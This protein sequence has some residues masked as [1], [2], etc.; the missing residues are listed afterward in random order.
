MVQAGPAGFLNE[1]HLVGAIGTTRWTCGMCQM[2][3]GCNYGPGM[4]GEPIGPPR[5]AV[6]PGVVVRP[7]VVV[8]PRLRSWVPRGP[9][10]CP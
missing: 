6:R 8:V 10:I 2:W 9:V 4:G 1:N 5:G 7:L 3:R